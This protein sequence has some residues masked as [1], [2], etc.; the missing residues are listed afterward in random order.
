MSSTGR[1][2]SSSFDSL[3]MDIIYGVFPNRFAPRI[4]EAEVL[5]TKIANYVCIAG[6]AILLY[7]SILTIPDEV[8]VIKS[9]YLLEPLPTYGCEGTIDMAGSS[10]IPKASLLYQPILHDRILALLHLQSVYFSSERNHNLC[11]VYGE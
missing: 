2:V 10:H 7:D 6:F 1:L 3:K 4:L 11:G 5:N 9:F 8:S